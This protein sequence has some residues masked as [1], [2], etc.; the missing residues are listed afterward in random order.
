MAA[1]LW[2]NDQ[3]LW[4]SIL[5]LVGGSI[6]LSIGGTAV[7]RIF[8][9]AQLLSLNNIVGGFKYL[10]ISSI[11]ASFLGFLLYGVYN[12]YD[13]V[14]SDV[15]S[16]VGELTTLDRLAAAFPDATRIRL[17]EGLKD[18]ANQVVEVEW[19]QLRGRNARLTTMTALDT[20]DYA[21][22]AV[23]PTSR[24]QREVVK[25]SRELL[26]KI[27]DTRGIRVLRSLGT[28]Q[29]LL[30]GVTLVSTAIVIVFPW[31]FGSPNINATIL[32]SIL[33]TLLMTSV[34]LV[35]LK[36]SYPFSGEYGIRPTPYTAFI[37]EVAARGN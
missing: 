9:G 26:G 15:I 19:P 25:Y 36:L 20:L 28:L 14:R 3:P 30:W 18:Y 17:R 33:S 24:K 5:V 37:Q 2:L 10:F 32:M 16:E 1:I 34:V 7:S 29:M 8:F 12:R 11:Y 35:V 13:N 27:R 31:V 21:Y 23:E 22:G 4:V 6:A